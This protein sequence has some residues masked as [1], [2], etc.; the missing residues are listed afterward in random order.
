MGITSLSCLEPEVTYT[1]KKFFLLTKCSYIIIIIYIYFLPYSLPNS[2][3]TISYSG[4]VGM[5]KWDKTCKMHSIYP[6]IEV[7]H[8][9]K[10]WVLPTLLSQVTYKWAQGATDD[11]RG[12][13]FF[14]WRWGQGEMLIILFLILNLKL[15][16]HLDSR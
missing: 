16:G 4:F 11:V 14:F 6:G 13:V 3:Y 1:F 8:F 9:F 5:V 7:I 12:C 10:N 15:V 2:S